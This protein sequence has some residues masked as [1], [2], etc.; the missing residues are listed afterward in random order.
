MRRSRSR[1][2]TTKA[3]LLDFAES[4]A[5]HAP[6]TP[7]FTRFANERY[8]VLLGPTPEF[9]SIQ[10]PRFPED[11]VEETVDELRDLVSQHGHRN[12][13]WWIP[14]SATPPD[15]V[16]RLLELGLQ[17]DERDPDLTAMVLEEPPAEPPPDI[18]VRAVTTEEEMAEAMA[19]QWDAFAISDSER[20]EQGRRVA[21]RFRLEQDYA[22]TKTFLAWVDGRPA[23]AAL[24]VFAPQGGL[25]V[26][27]S[28]QP[29]ARGRGAYRAL[30][31]ARWDAAVERG[32][33]TLVVQAGAMSG[34][35]V[36]RL[37]FVPVSR[38]RHLVDVAGAA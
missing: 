5:A 1:T 31:R 14:D 16:D 8:V 26:G 34:P 37:G 3:D 19:I 35:I 13:K 6:I 7:D 17:P 11:G 27:G 23:A 22:F 38:V 4:P 18:T 21:D 2:S 9:T 24:A 30:V 25:L 36:R 28:T 12:A 15:L 29:W 10:R 32:T 20:A 33:P